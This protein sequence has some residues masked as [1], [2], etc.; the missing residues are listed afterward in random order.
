[1]LRLY[2]SEFCFLQGFDT[3]YCVTGGHPTCKKLYKQIAEYSLGV[4]SSF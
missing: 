2:Q 3:V 4:L 1:M